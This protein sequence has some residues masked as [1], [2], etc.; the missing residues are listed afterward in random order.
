[1]FFGLG[2]SFAAFRRVFSGELAG[3]S[4]F[5]L[6]TGFSGGP[7]KPFSVPDLTEKIGG[8]AK[9]LATVGAGRPREPGG[10]GGRRFEIE[11]LG[12]KSKKRI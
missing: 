2:V 4:P 3:G 11:R 1:L 6:R 12:K 7:D 5:G 8:A 10:R 9:T